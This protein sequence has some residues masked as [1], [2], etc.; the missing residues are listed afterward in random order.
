MEREFVGVAAGRG[1]REFEQERGQGRGRTAAD[2]H[3]SVVADGQDGDA[4]QAHKQLGW[5]W[6]LDA[7]VLPVDLLQLVDV[8]KQRRLRC[9]RTVRLQLQTT[10]QVVRL[11]PGYDMLKTAFAKVGVSLELA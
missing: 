4:S 9:L 3:A 7:D 10:K 2:R 11:L 5:F 8:V 1:G 6:E